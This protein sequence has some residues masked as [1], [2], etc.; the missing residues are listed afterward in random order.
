MVVG[1]LLSEVS[2]NAE[3][4]AIRIVEPLS[5]HVQLTFTQLNVSLA[6]E[7]FSCR[8]VGWQMR[9]RRRPIWDS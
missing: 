9:S 5:A 6:T 2:T 1:D 8:H 3:S 4:A 7:P